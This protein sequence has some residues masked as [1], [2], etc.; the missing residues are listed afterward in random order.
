VEK[1]ATIQVA[2]ETIEKFEEHIKRVTTQKEYM[3]AKKQVE[4]ARRLNNQL[5]DEILE[6]RVQQEELAPKLGEV[7]E[8][9]GKVLAAYQEIEGEILKEQTGLENEATGQE[10]ELKALIET[11]GDQV[12]DYY[13]RLVRAGKAPGIV[14]VIGGTCGGC[15]MAIPPQSYN[16]VIAQPERVHT[17][18]HCSRI[19]YYKPAETVIGEEAIVPEAQSGS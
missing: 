15:N 10:A 4:E 14:Q 7:R 18:S 17:C 19:I 11:L 8:R 13:Q 2:L 1:E 3:A 6:S 12:W 5:Q 9:H 16:L